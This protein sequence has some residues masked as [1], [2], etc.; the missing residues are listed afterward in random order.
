MRNPFSQIQEASGKSARKKCMQG[1]APGKKSVSLTC[2]PLETRK[3]NR[4]R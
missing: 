1:K 4:T 2:R 3:E